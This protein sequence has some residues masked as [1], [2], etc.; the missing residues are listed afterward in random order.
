MRFLLTALLSSLALTA[1]AQR[2][3]PKITA[4]ENPEAYW[5][6]GFGCSQTAENY[7]VTLRVAD[8]DAMAARVDTLMT[9]AGAPSQMGQTNS[10]YYASQGGQGRMRQMNYSVSIKSADKLAKKLMDMGEL[11]NYSLNRSQSGDSLAQIEE[12]IAVLEGELKNEDALAKLPSAAHFLNAKLRSLKQSREVC[13]AGATRSS[14]SVSL[15]AQ[16][17]K[18]G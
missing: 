5:N 2:P 17:G 13:L 11:I 12:R 10:G 1:Q 15:Q 4:Q 16:P 18:P 14:I 9:D 3:G 7:N 8:V 6:R